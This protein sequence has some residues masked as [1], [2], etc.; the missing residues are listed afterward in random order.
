MSHLERNKEVMEVV[1]GPKRKYRGPDVEIG[2]M[3][4]VFQRRLYL[5]SNAAPL[6]CCES[7]V[8]RDPMPDV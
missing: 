8:R 2:T 5:S 3:E 1:A 6:Y 7:P 4:F